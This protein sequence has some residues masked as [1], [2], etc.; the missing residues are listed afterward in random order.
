MNEIKEWFYRIIALAAIYALIR[1]LWYIPQR[2]KYNRTHRQSILVVS[3]GDVPYF[4][5]EFFLLPYLGSE[6]QCF[7]P[8]K[9]DEK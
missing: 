2:V 3:M 7:K 8:A 4:F 9:R 6:T 5:V 1:L